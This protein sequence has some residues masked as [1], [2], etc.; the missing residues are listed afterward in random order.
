M[1]IKPKPHIPQ[2][3]LR[4]HKNAQAARKEKRPGYQVINLHSSHA[5]ATTPPDVSYLC[6]EYF[7]KEGRWP[8]VLYLP[9][10][11]SSCVVQVIDGCVVDLKVREAP[12]TEPEV[13]Y[14]RQDTPEN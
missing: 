14:E 10:A 9:K 8:N 4:A 12:V 2:D 5:S 7:T 3:K 11:R 13:G 6:R 1:F